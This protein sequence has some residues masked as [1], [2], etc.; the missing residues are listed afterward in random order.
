LP[1]ACYA[2]DQISN[3]GNALSRHRT[4]DL[5]PRSKLNKPDRWVVFSLPDQ[6]R[7]YPKADIAERDRDVRFVP[8]ADIALLHSITSS[9]RPTQAPS[10]PL[11][12]A[13]SAPGRA[14][15]RVDSRLS[16]LCCSTITSLRH[17]TRQAPIPSAGGIVTVQAG[18]LE[19]VSPALG[20]LRFTSIADI[21]DHDRDVCFVPKGGPCGH[22]RQALSVL[23]GQGG[24]PATLSGLAALLR[25]H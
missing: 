15:I 21:T 10:P 2:G 13:S 20:N 14:S 3:L 12:L 23:P 1:H 7:L 22:G 8:K 18:R 5:H 9:A 4:A 17:N 19:V 16:A 6:C 11:K 24:S 25:P